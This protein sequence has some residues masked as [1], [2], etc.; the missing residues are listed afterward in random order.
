LLVNISNASLAVTGSLGRTWTLASG[1][2]SVT[3]T[4]ITNPLPAGTNLLGQVIQGVQS[5]AVQTFVGWQSAS[6]TLLNTS[7]VRQTSIIVNNATSP[8]CITFG[9]VANLNMCT[10]MIPPMQ[11]WAIPNTVTYRGPISGRWVASGW[12]EAI[13]TDIPGG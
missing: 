10:A 5:G 12:G 13:I 2:D 9:A 3:V 4:S 1:T 7:S 8:L 11:S 6:V